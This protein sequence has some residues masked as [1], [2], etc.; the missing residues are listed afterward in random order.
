MQYPHKKFLSA[1]TAGR[2]VRFLAV[3]YLGRIYGRQM[4]GF[5][6]RYYRPLLYVLIALAVI[7]GVGV[8]AYFKWYRP[9]AQ[10]KTRARDKGVEG[11]A[12]PIPDSKSRKKGNDR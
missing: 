6:S 4:I 10:R 11:F 3:A 7:A 1:L 5:F 9:A 12:A 2:T 8:L